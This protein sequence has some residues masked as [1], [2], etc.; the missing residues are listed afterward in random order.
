MLNLT[1]HAEATHW[2]AAYIGLAYGI[3]FTCWDVVRAVQRDVYARDLPAMQIGFEPS[4]ENWQA[5]R[6]TLAGSAWHRVFDG[7]REGDV[8]LMRGPDGP[9]VGVV[10]DHCY[11]LSLLHNLGSVDDGIAHGSVRVDPIHALGLLGY[12]RFE[13]WRHP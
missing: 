6:E 11:N 4:P 2:S 13:Y 1:P 12:G 3:D 7:G 5:L 9:H 10:V 8:L